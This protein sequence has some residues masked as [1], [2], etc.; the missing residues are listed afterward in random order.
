M[1]AL[2]TAWADY[3]VEGATPSR[4]VTNARLAALSRA[5][6]EQRKDA[7]IDLAYGDHPR[8]RL[9]IFPAKGGAAPVVLFMHGGYWRLGDKADRAFPAPAF[10][11]QGIA[12]AAMNYPLAPA[13]S[14][15]R[16]VTAARRAVHWLHAHASG[17]GIDPARIHLCGNSAGA[18]L[19]AMVMA[20]A[21]A[22]ACVAGATLI[23]GLFDLRPLLPL[24]INEVLGLTADMAAANSP[25]LLPPPGNRV[26]ITVGEH[27]PAGFPA[28]SAAFHAHC[29]AASPVMAVPGADHFSILNE[30][31]RPDTPL[32]AAMLQQIEAR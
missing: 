17:Y 26:L 21:A 11:E 4:P 22:G 6:R 7:A 15:E 25:L 13:S 14:I 20:D 8:E 24:P 29:A 32:A 31:R 12:W 27:E 9:D 23:S 16:I 28:H 2:P 18:H 1:T 5:V 30:L 10:A 3:D 19:A